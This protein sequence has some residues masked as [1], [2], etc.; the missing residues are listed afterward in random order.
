MTE[1]Y[2]SH[3]IIQRLKAL[4]TLDLRSLALFRIGFGLILIYEIGGR[5]LD[6]ADFY[7]ENSISQA[8]QLRQYW[9]HFGKPGWILPSVNFLS[10]STTF[11]GLLFALSGIMA[12]CFTL[13]IATRVS[14]LV[15]SYLFASY[16]IRFH[17]LLNGSD[18]LYIWFLLW[19][20]FLPLD[21]KNKN[22]LNTSVCSWTSAG[23]IF[24]IGLIY[25]MAGLCK[26]DPYW[27]D[28][29]AIQRFLQHS[30]FTTRYIHF[31]EP[32]PALCAWLSF[33]IPKVEIL[34]PFLL[35]CTGA[36]GR[37]R[38]AQV[39]GMIL[40]HSMLALSFHIG[41][42]SPICI[43]AWVA[44]LPAE[45]WRWFGRPVVKSSKALGSQSIF[46]SSGA[47]LLILLV[48]TGYIN[49]LWETIDQRHKPYI[50]WHRF[51]R[52]GVPMGW[53]PF[54]NPPYEA[55]W[56]QFLGKKT[57]QD[58]QEIVLVDHRITDVRQDWPANVYEIYCKDRNWQRLFNY[59][60]IP[61]KRN[62]LMTGLQPY[63]CRLY[64]HT[65]PAG[66]S[67]IAIIKRSHSALASADG[68]DSR[69]DPFWNNQC[70]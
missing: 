65:S 45:F 13:G 38:I 56:L 50:S 55:A 26:I 53:L 20:V 47:W 7:G 32:Y 29:T 40:M 68:I 16:N 19:S 57:G 3:P 21:R 41:T 6:L 51:D 66:F 34:T 1:P 11:Q 10:S 17:W 67:E 46:E 60:L 25:W 8:D 22:T 52:Y 28:G 49:S 58:W 30:L 44:L 14:A 24:Q 69:S 62:D 23:F 36:S 39:F 27:L 48:T 5:F 2:K 12:I 54:T 18:T 4:A 70:P 15:L 43:A 31:L 63:L 61:K 37:L 42:I 33:T 64:G 35:V 59:L 9:M